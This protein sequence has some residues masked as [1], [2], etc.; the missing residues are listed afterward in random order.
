MLKLSIPLNLQIIGTCM[1]SLLLQ[2]CHGDAQS[3]RHNAKS[4]LDAALIETQSVMLDESGKAKIPSASLRGGTIRPSVWIV[5]EMGRSLQSKPVVVDTLSS[6]FVWV[7]GLRNGDLVV[8]TSDSG[9]KFR[10]PV[11]VVAKQP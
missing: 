7:R 6:K 9:I 2:G 3:S 11:V 10:D 8:T 5:N 1:A 4:S